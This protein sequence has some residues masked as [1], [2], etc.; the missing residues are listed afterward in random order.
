MPRNYFANRVNTS[1]VSSAQKR[2]LEASASGR[3]YADQL[4]IDRK[5]GLVTAAPALATPAS[6]ASAP[7]RPA[8]PPQPDDADD[9]DVV[10]SG[11]V[12]T[13]GGGLTAL[14]FAAREGDLESTRA[15]LDAGA[16]V[17]QQTTYGWTPC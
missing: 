5:A 12:G 3:S 17:N 15:L 8:L 6:A 16:D 10:V 2:R 13:G 7:V 1:A 9:A 14:V 4:E 11:L